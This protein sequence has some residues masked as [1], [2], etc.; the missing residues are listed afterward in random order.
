MADD[1]IPGVA[2]GLAALHAWL[3]DFPQLAGFRAVADEAADAASRLSDFD[4]A[5]FAARVLAVA[6]EICDR[7]SPPPAPPSTAT[8]ATVAWEAVRALVRASGVAGSADADEVDVDVDGARCDAP[9]GRL[10][11]LSALLCHALSDRCARQQ[12]YVGR[13]VAGGRPAVQQELMRIIQEHGPG[14]EGDDNDETGDYSAFIDTSF[15]SAGSAGGAPSSDGED[16]DESDGESDGEGDAKRDRTEAFGDEIFH[17]ETPPE[18]KSPSSEG[19]GWGGSGGSSRDGEGEGADEDPVA[20]ARVR[21]QLE[22]SR[23]READVAARLDEERARHRA[24]MLQAESRHLRAARDLE[25]RGAAAVAAQ[26]AERDALRD[27]AREA[28]EAREDNARLRDD[29]DVLARARE[30]HAHAEEQLRRCREKLAAAGDAAA[31][32]AREERAHAAAV[33]RCLAL[34]GELARTRPLQRQ[35]EEC[36]VRSAD[37]EAALAECREDLRRAK[38]R[39]RGLEGA[40]MDLERDVGRRRAEDGAL[41]RRLQEG[42]SG[43]EGGTVVGSG[44]R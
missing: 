28:R 20:V 22:E 37:A 23:R 42:G 6:E 1:D 19:G 44:M 24:A 16:E 18:K 33:D 5:D 15:L 10:A 35:L 26:R 9:D 14:G 3:C 4:R 38:E 41:Q 12:E 29:L 40:H 11:I 7:A 30:E 31:A 8:G 13:I 17:P 2:R 27:A 39:T 32:L 34:E 36:R 25:A 43:G 21:E